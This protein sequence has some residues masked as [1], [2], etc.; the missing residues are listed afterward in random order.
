MAFIPFPVGTCEV[1]LNLLYDTNPGQNTLGLATIDGSPL[2][3]SEGELIAAAIGAWWS[4]N[5]KAKCMVGTILTNVLVNDLTSESGWQAS[6][7]AGT[8]G[9]VTGD[10][11]PNNAA[12]VVKFLS[13]LRGRSYR[14]RNFFGGVPG[15]VLAAN[16]LWTTV[17]AAS[18]GAAYVALNPAL[19]SLNVEHV[20]LSRYEA[21]AP[22]STGHVQPVVSYVADTHIGSMRGRLS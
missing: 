2:T 1:I 3:A 10:P 22:R 6:Y 7:T 9:T 5:C 17:F 21:K 18:V 19:L 8:A 20:I 13:G 15:N 12:V 16:N 4:T 11:A 14:G